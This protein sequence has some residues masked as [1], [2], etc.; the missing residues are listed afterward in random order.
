MKLNLTENLETL[1]DFL[2][3][4]LLQSIEGQIPTHPRHLA[5]Q[6]EAAD[7]LKSAELAELDEFLAHPDYR[8]VGQIDTSGDT[9]TL[10]KGETWSDHERHSDPLFI[11]C[12]H[13]RV[14]LTLGHGQR[15]DIL[16]VAGQSYTSRPGDLPVI[17][18]LELA[19]IRLRGAH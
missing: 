5:S 15:D 1:Q 14:W 4:H 11:E 2:S 10:H 17:E 16:L 9:I 19:Q 7:G 3:R 13:G 12:T 18:A 8:G 6:A